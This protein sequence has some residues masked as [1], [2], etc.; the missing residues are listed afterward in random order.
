MEF[1]TQKLTKDLK[2]AAATLTDNEARFL[3]DSYYQMQRM[4][5][6]ISAQIRSIDQAPERELKEKFNNAVT[7][8][9]AAMGVKDKEA[10][11]ILMENG[12]YES[13][14]A[15]ISAKEPHETLGFFLN[16]YEYM[17]QDLKKALEQYVKAQPIG[18]WMTSI[19]GIG[20]V[21]AAGLIAYIDI[22]QAP[23]AGHIWSYAGLNPDSIWEKGQKRPF[24]A[25]LKKLC[26]KIGES[27]IKTQ[28]RDGD[29]YGHIFA[30]RKV[31]EIENNEAGLYADK[32]AEKLEKFDIQEPITL[33]IYQNGKLPPG[34]IH[35]RAR[36][37]AVKMFLSHLQQVWWEMETG[38]KPPKPFTIGILGHA[39][40]IE[41]PNWP[42]NE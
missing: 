42:M 15:S 27:F 21:I 31:L 28:N 33:A 41:P 6:T 20:P 19:M 37:Y 10:R 11:A 2:K 30:E 9:A 25:D 36:R 5:I 39:H 22:R 24:N 32:A 1:S 23:T 14:V 18:R 17:E 38:E 3:V 13:I 4:R 29:I 35:A 12:T 26:W 16:N 34:H 7:A 8:F 40:L